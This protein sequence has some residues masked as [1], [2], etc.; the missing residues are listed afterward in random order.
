MIAHL[1][2]AWLTALDLYYRNREYNTEMP[3]TGR[4]AKDLSY[5]SDPA[6]RLD[7]LVPPSRPPYPIVINVHGGGWLMGDKASYSRI[8]HCFAAKGYLTANCNYRLAPRHR[9]PAQLRDI[10]TAV[11][12]VYE[13]A[14]EYG[15][16]P[17]R[18][19]LM[20]DSAGAHLVTCYTLAP[21]SEDLVNELSGL[22][23]VPDASLRAL[24]LFYGIY[25]LRQLQGEFNGLG[26]PVV[27]SFLAPKAAD[28]DKLMELISPLSHIADSMPPCFIC[29]GEL[30]ALFAQSTAL[31]EHLR[32]K[33]IEHQVLLLSRAEYP[34]ARHGFLNYHRRPSAGI[35]TQTALEFLEKHEARSSMSTDEERSR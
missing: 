5:G 25:N 9:H 3:E 8:C 22:E 11:R 6:R 33:D 14:P 27:R 26:R 34:D 13:H 19:Y 7:I 18:I 15:G 31:V 20:G 35:A 29:C 16:D 17:S 2:K 12:W 10:A 23:L 1:I 24:L 21:H 28:P 32:M 4:V 30:D